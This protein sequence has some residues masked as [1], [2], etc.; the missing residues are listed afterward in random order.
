[1]T[2]PDALPLL[3]R[4]AGARPPAPE[5]AAPEGAAQL[6]EALLAATRVAGAGLRGLEPAPAGPPEASC[7]AREAAFEAL[8]SP[9]LYFLTDPAGP[10]GGV[11]VLET[12]LVDAL[13]E[14]QTLG[15]VNGAAP[16]GRPPTRVDAALCQP[17]AAAALRETATRLAPDAPAWARPG[18]I[19]GNA[20]L[21]A[22]DRLGLSLT[23]ERYVTVE[24]ALTLGGGERTGRLWCLL[25]A[26]PE[27]RP[28]R[29]RS[30]ARPPPPF[31]EALR[32]ALPHL[33]VSLEAR[34]TLPAITA[35]R[36]ADLQTG[37][38]L[39]LPMRSLEEVR[40]HGG[41]HGRGPRRGAT[42]GGKLGQLNG[43]RAVRLAA[44]VPPPAAEPGTQEGSQPGEPATLE[45]VPAPADGGGR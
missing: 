23:A 29:P 38:L 14:V 40:L 30:S 22:P 11:V 21:G 36:L 28:A 16:P 19:R 3:R 2:D 45:G 20:F 33:R 31:E 43:R 5:G 17:F 37:D 15:R 12:A 44:G 25:P 41:R 13:V 6:G 27:A 18:A 10:A 9:A 39:R 26:P 32:D 42:L 7:A 24:L 34:L 8:P 4:M 35:G 1:M